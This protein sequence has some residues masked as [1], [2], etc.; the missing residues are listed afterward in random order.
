[1]IE[2][3]ETEHDIELRKAREVD[4]E[5]VT[6]QE[7][8]AI[9]RH[10]LVRDDQFRLVDVHVPAVDAEHEVAGALDGLEGPEP[11]VAPEVEHALAGEVALTQ[12]NERTHD[13]RAPLRVSV[14]VVAIE[15]RCLDAVAEVELI[16]PVR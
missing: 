7:R 10:I 4:R 2:Q 13:V 8:V 15:D 5:D 11:G 3:P 12:F 1:V 6:A 9:G 14:D 16:V